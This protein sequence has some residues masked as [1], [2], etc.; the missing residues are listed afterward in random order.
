[1][2]GKES[3]EC[4]YKKKNIEKDLWFTKLDKKKKSNEWY[5][6]TKNI[7]KGLMD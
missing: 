6:K 1:M 4:Y 3:M 7:K 2:T 5:Y